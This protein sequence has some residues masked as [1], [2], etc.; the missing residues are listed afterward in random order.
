MRIDITALTCRRYQGEEIWERELA[1]L[2]EAAAS[3]DSGSVTA[4]TAGPDWSH[5]E[6]MTL[7]GPDS[8]RVRIASV[9]PTASLSPAPGAALP[10]A[11][12]EE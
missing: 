10:T 7:D 12:A 8:G 4:A 2:F 9:P 1:H 11:D 3:I 5:A 6:I